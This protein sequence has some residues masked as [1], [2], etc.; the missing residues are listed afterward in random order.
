MQAVAEQSPAVARPTPKPLLQRY[1]ALD[2][3]RGFIMLVLCSGGF[4]LKA[5]SA[6]AAQTLASWFDHA[7]WEGCVFW[8]L[9]Q[10]AFMFMVGMALP[11]ALA[12]RTARGATASQNF[13]HVAV[14][15]IKLLL[16]SQILMCIGSGKLYFQA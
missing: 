15:A 13:R 6:P 8:D 7:A 11:F 9:I 4:G 12:I 5:V 2:A 1:E 16:L 10:P 3:Y 14:R